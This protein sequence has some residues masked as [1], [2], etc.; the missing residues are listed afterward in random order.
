MHAPL[1]HGSVMPA[2]LMFGVA[3]TTLY[4]YGRKEGSDIPRLDHP[5][6]QL[7]R[8]QWVSLNGPWEFAETDE[9]ADESF[10]TA[11]TYPDKIVVPFCRESKRSGLERRGFVRNVWYRRQFERPTS[12][13]A[14]R[15]RLHVGAC[16]Y[17]T[18]VWINGK[19]VGRHVGG[20]VGFAFDITD[21]LQDGTNTVIIHAFDDTRSGKQAL[22]KQSRELE[23]KGIFYTRTTGIWQPV[24]LEGVGDTF[25]RSY[26]VTCEPNP[27]RVLLEVNAD[28]PT[29]GLTLS[30]T[31]LIDN[32]PVGTAAV[33]LGAESANLV[34]D[35]AEKRLWSPGDP[36][37]YDLKL[38]IRRGDEVIDELE[39]YFGL[40]TVS[41]E[42]RMILI[43]GRP[44]FQRLVLDQ[45]FY[46]DGVWTAPRDFDLRRDISLSQAMGFN[47]ARLHQKVFD[48]RFLY[49]ADKLGY[50]VWGE[51]P[52]FGADYD[53]PAVNLPIIDEWVEILERDFNHPS[54]IGWC[55]FNE[56][57]PAAGD[58][59]NAV[60]RI[61]RSIDPTRPVLD[62]SGWTHSLPDPE[63]FDA[64]DY[65][66]NPDSFRARWKRW[67]AYPDLHA[68]YGRWRRDLPFFVSEYGGIGWDTGKGWGYGKTP[69]SLEAFHERYEGLT[70]AL[71]DNPKMF[72]FCYTQLTDVEQEKNGL[73]TFERE[74]KFDDK[75]I[76]LINSRPAAYETDPP[77][78]DK[79]TR[80][81]WQVLV[82]G[83]PDGP[84][85]KPWRYTTDDPDDGWQKADFDDGDWKE[86]LGAFGRKADWQSHI[87]TEWRSEKIWLRQSFT[88]DATG[89][90]AAV[91][92]I[93]HDDDVEVFLNGQPI[94][95]DERWTDDYQ[96]VD[97]TA[98]VKQ[99]LQKG[100]NTLAVV[101]HQTRGGQYIDAA[102][103]TG[104]A[105][106]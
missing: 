86:G 66:Q 10:L 84:Q 95:S 5:R 67:F 53:N 1:N 9:D 17:A 45:G 41:I 55:P 103:L 46:P 44:I 73:Y 96:I 64:H 24:W 70:M 78:T 43:N 93:H 23:S 91:L 56:T 98:T 38:V 50:L 62:T 27:S 22:G 29:T 105:G 88:C 30:A 4:A 6:P 37:L 101:C 28:G 20:N 7:E 71:L 92:A 104:K 69:E 75:K 90:D 14:P 94:W 58:L 40:R 63:V 72:G 18:R 54:I 26:R 57:P 106:K 2:L 59:Q 87:R 19:F 25:I 21:A 11:E 89:F 49:W 33:S 76:R 48:P 39:S 16:D 35:L 36:F 85:A 13:S 102:L 81:S 51:Y 74:A 99:A 12:W 61:T 42:G 15:T 100:D 60:V 83:Q 65:D 8:D 97:V 32:K 31:A 68:R 52:S 79:Q 34:L 3:A 80:M 47:G 77:T 82:A